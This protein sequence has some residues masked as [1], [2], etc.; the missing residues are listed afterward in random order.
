MRIQ[1][2][3][4]AL[5]ALFVVGIL[6]G[7]RHTNAPVPSAATTTTKATISAGQAWS[8]ADALGRSV[9]IPPPQTV[10]AAYGS[11][12][13]TWL[14]AGGE[15]AGTTQDAVSERQLTLSDDVA[16]I[17]TVKTPDTERIAALSPDFVMLSADIAGHVQMD[18]MLTAMHIPHAYFRVDTYRDYLTMLQGCC[19]LTGRNDLYEKNG[20]A[21]ER[22]IQEVLR[23]VPPM[24]KRPT[25]LLIRAFSTGA[26]AKGADNLAGVIL[27]ELQTDNLV[28]RHE[29]LLE[30]I[31]MEAI[32]QEDPD[33]IFVPVMGADEQKALD[34]LKNGIQ[35]NPAWSELTAVKNGRYH[36][37]P[38]N[39]FHYKPNARWGESYAYLANI[40]Y[41]EAMG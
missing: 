18:D 25:V 22:D 28:E 37:L 12:A 13:E 9:T 3:G 1:R 17:G 8:F 14:L 36:V 10:V 26:K 21:V 4:A 15:L 24:E 31:S 20:A 39:L 6:S 32:I 2:Y 7:C 35:R 27:Q 11:F 41:P 38:K 5:A 16:I 30:D 40:I 34:A 19:R 29:S 23:R 33:Y